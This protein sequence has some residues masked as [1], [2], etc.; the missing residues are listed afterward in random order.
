MIPKQL[1]FEVP[2]FENKTNYNRGYAKLKVN[3]PN[4]LYEQRPENHQNCYLGCQP[5]A[6]EV[7]TQIIS[8]TTVNLRE[9]DRRVRYLRKITA[10]A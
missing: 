4:L 7:K 10:R 6:I 1:L 5:M 2:R 9:I 8:T 3:M